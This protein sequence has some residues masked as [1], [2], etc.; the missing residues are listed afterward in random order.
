MRNIYCSLNSSRQFLTCCGI[1]SNEF[2]VNSK[3]YLHNILLLKSDYVGIHC[4]KGFDA[5][6]GAEE[7]QSF[8]STEDLRFGDF[9][10]VD[11]LKAADLDMLTPTQISEL[12]Y[13]AHM[14]ELLHDSFFPALQNHFIFL[15]HDDSNFIKLFYNQQS[16]VINI[17]CKVIASSF[18][19][20]NETTI[21]PMPQTLVNTIFGL[22]EQGVII[23]R[24]CLRSAGNIQRLSLYI[25]GNIADM[26]FL[27]NNEAEA[28]ATAVTSKTLVYGNQ[29]WDII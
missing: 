5:L 23:K 20:Y 22:F 17:L 24:S 26:D 15:S 19:Q 25:I 16:V 10:F 28:I 1:S 18:Q 27:I 9:C 21:A 6:L 11:F 2:Y 7:I 3:E 12:L 8:F 4:Y 14:K 13:A 29:K